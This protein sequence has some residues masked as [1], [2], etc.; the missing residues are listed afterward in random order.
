MDNPDTP[1]RLRE[2]PA[3]KY[4]KYLALYLFLGYIFFSLYGVL[5]Q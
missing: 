1:P 2:R 4:L 3:F 5:S